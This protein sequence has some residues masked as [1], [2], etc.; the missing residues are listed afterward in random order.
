MDRTFRVCII[1]YIL[2]STYICDT[3]PQKAQSTK[4]QPAYTSLHELY[5]LISSVGHPVRRWPCC[6]GLCTFPGVPLI[7]LSEE[8]E[9]SNTKSC[10]FDPPGHGP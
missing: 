10:I 9:Q 6:V 4:F 5:N 7:W 1:C 3:T 2:Y 8:M